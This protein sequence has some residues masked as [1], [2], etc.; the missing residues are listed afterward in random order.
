MKQDISTLSEAELKAT[1]RNGFVVAILGG[2]FTVD[3]IVGCKIELGGR[4]EE[5]GGA[6]TGLVGATVG[7][8]RTGAG[9]RSIGLSWHS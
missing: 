5:A 2:M 6:R 7:A 3:R 9:R 1:S 4:D 8:S